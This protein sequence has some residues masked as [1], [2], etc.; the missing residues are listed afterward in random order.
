MTTRADF[1]EDEWKALQKG[2][3]GAGVLV[4]ISDR[5]FTDSFGEATAIAKYLAEQ[6]ETS[7]SA[8]V[9]DLAKV[10]GTGFG[11]TA[12]LQEVEAETLDALR[13]ATE[14]LSAK[15]P[16]ELDAYRALVVDVADRAANAKGGLS[17][18]EA[19]ALEKVK[20]VL[21]QA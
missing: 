5:D 10:K 2:V 16:E 9:R 18:E 17:P 21:G 19:S 1:T 6:R 20:G 4:S 8:V 15:A 13:S 3:T 7:D 14:I 12:S 11:L